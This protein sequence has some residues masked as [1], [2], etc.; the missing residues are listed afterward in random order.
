M[1]PFVR[2]Y[3]DKT[4]A[5]DVRR[6]DGLLP[7]IA[8]AQRTLSRNPR[9]TVGTLTQVSPLIRLLFSRAGLRRCVRCEHV[10]APM[11]AG[12]IAARLRGARVEVLAVEAPVP[13]QLDARV[14][15]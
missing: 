7:A 14:V 10:I 8:I 9:S 13:G 4:S 12:E 11:E 1:S 6:V 3:L 15:S 5:P 2:R